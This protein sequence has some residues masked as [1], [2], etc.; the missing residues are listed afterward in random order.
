MYVITYMC[1]SFTDRT[2][3]FSFLIFLKLYFTSNLRQKINM[4]LD[5]IL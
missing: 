2:V 1:R 3:F 4:L 5:N